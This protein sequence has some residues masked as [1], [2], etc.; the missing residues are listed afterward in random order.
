MIEVLSSF[1]M[2]LLTH[3]LFEHYDPSW[4]FL[5][6]QKLDLANRLSKQKEREKQI[7]I[8]KLD[9][10]TN[11]ER[12]AMMQKQKFGLSNWHKQGA[13]QQEEYVKSDEYSTHTESERQERLK[14]IL[15]QSNVELDF[16]HSRD[17][18]EE[19]GEIP[20]A[21]ID[22]INDEEGYIDYEDLDEDNEDYMGSMMDEEQQQEFNE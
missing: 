10:A 17:D 1:V 16:L 5:N 13:E 22:P 8:D 9:G 20:G 19:V 2:D 14:E 4:L 11:E 21:V 15:A 6:E 12:F 7:L 18:N 3:I